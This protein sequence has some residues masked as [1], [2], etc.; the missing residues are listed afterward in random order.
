[1]KKL[2]PAVEVIHSGHQDG[3]IEKL[4]ILVAQQLSRGQANPAELTT[5]ELTDEVLLQPWVLPRE[6]ASSILR[7]LPVPHQDKFRYC[8]EDY[9]CFRCGTKNKPHQ[10]LGLCATCHGR[11]HSRIKTSISKRVKA[12]HLEMAKLNVSLLTGSTTNAKRA[13]QELARNYPAL[14]EN[15][16]ANP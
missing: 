2:Q 14:T 3:A 4:A 6:I 1:M 10:S 15:T 5:E 9:G 11:L 7:L 16:K 13:L 12:D 8:Y